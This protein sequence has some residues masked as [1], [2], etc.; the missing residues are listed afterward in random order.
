MPVK[1]RI[2]MIT[3]GPGQKGRRELVPVVLGAAHNAKEGRSVMFNRTT[4][5]RRR[6]AKRFLPW[7]KDI[8][9]VGAFYSDGEAIDFAAG[10]EDKDWRGED[11]EMDAFVRIWARISEISTFIELISLL[12][13][14]WISSIFA[15]RTFPSSIH[16]SIPINLEPID[17]MSRSVSMFWF[18]CSCVRG[19]T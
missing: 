3:F 4:P 13:P 17:A 6:T 14:I 8:P 16:D 2:E 5:A 12:K 9:M 7:S 10:G 19:T 1:E 15:T 11:S 18:A